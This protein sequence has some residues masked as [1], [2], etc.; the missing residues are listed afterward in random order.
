MKSLVA[1][2]AVLVGLSGIA[3]GQ[4]SLPAPDERPMHPGTALLD[5]MG[6]Y[7]GAPDPAARQSTG[8]PARRRRWRSPPRTAQASKQP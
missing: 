1:G 4:N 6:I 8:K 7:A 3:Y 2:L 5:S